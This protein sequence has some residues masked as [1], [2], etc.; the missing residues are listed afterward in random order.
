MQPSPFS[1]ISIPPLYDR[2]EDGVFSPGHVP[3]AVPSQSGERDCGPRLTW[4]QS[5][6]CPSQQHCGEDFLPSAALPGG[7]LAVNAKGTFSSTADTSVKSSGSLWMLRLS[8][9]KDFSHLV[10][11]SSCQTSRCPPQ[12]GWFNPRAVLGKAFGFAFWLLRG[13][14]L[15]ELWLSLYS[16]S[17]LFSIPLIPPLVLGEGYL[18]VLKHLGLGLVAVSGSMVAMVPLGPAAV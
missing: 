11:P 16:P 12:D 17:L 15:W 2:D 3:V 1:Y 4:E 8:L 5:D 13:I 14:L 7:K 6:L 10:V 9:Y 18:I